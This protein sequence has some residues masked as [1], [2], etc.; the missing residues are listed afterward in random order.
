MVDLMMRDR[1]DAVLVTRKDNSID[2]TNRRA[3]SDDARM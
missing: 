3:G 1:R 2:A